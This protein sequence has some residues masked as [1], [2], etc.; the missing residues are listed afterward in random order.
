MKRAEGTFEEAL[1]R[2]Y[3]YPPS[4]RSP[5]AGTVVVTWR[6]RVVT[7]SLMLALL[8]VIALIAWVDHSD[9]LPWLAPH[10]NGAHWPAGNAYAPK[11]DQFRPCGASCAAPGLEMHKFTFGG[12]T[13]RS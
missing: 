6:S 4:I 12:T 2:G 3:R 13:S 7:L 11:G 10:S 1:A 8:A 9:E 5:G